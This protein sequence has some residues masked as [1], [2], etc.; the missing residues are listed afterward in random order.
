VSDASVVDD[1]RLRETAR[2]PIVLRPGGTQPVF[3]IAVSEGCRG[4]RERHVARA[5]LH[6]IQHLAYGYSCTQWLAHR[7]LQGV[8]AAAPR[9]RVAV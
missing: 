2:S 5:L 4:R 9:R 7:F 1:H 6:F 8:T 3:A